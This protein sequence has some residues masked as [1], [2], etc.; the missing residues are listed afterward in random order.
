MKGGWRHV[1]ITKKCVFD[2]QK[3]VSYSNIF[4]EDIIWKGETRFL[5]LSLFI[6]REN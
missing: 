5:S 1:L 4:N 3:S 2:G 6:K